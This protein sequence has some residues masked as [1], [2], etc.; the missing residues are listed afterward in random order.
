VRF[1]S[2]GDDV[3]VGLRQDV[4]DRHGPSAEPGSYG[5]GHLLDRVS[6]DELVDLIDGCQH[7][8]IHLPDA[9]RSEQTDP[10]ECSLLCEVRGAAPLR[11]CSV[12]CCVLL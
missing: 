6:D 2:G 8:G 10:H 9:T 1:A 11:R 7:L 5:F 12:P 4:L 3:C